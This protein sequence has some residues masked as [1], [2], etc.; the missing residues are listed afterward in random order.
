MRQLYPEGAARLF[1]DVN[2]LQVGAALEAQH[3][4]HRQLSK[5]VLVV[6]QD[7]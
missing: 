4:V 7:L 5:V 2:G 6:R 3:G 1:D